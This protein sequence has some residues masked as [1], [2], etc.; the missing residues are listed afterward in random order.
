[1]IKLKIGGKGEIV[2]PKKI[3]EYL[4]LT[5]NKTVTLSVEDKK[6]V[7]KPDQSDIA[8]KWTMLA[9]KHREDTSKW[10]R[11]DAMYEDVFDVP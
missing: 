6:I 2:I 10:V 11:G 8:A 5:K 4:G 1:M 9:T 7:L 3:R